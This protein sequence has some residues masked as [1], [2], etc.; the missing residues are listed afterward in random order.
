MVKTWLFLLHKLVTYFER[1]NNFETC[2]L[3]RSLVTCVE[4]WSL[5]VGRV[6]VSRL[7]TL[8]A[9]KWY[10]T[11]LSVAVWDKHSSVVLTGLLV[12]DANFIV[13]LKLK[14]IT[15]FFFCVL[16]VL[17]FA[18]LYQTVCSSFPLTIRHNNRYQ[19]LTS[20][21]HQRLPNRLLSGRGKVF[22]DQLQRFVDWV[23]Q[24]FN[25]ERSVFC[26]CNL[27][28]IFWLLKRL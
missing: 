8:L 24:T 26:N 13:W 27:L 22:I 15:G 12:Q 7:I 20:Q 25:Y 9:S 21:R 5:S 10:R 2:Y 14:R 28:L 17:A 4:G 3:I 23:W 19:A 11:L 6:W 16:R 18:R 1:R